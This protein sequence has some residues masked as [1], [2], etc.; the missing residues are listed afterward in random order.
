MYFIYFLLSILDQ[1]TFIALK[2]K[3][4]EKF[5][6]NLCRMDMRDIFKNSFY[7]QRDLE[8]ILTNT[9]SVTRL[10]NLYINRNFLLVQ[11]SSKNEFI[12]SVRHDYLLQFQPHYLLD[13]NFNSFLICFESFLIFLYSDQTKNWHSFKEFW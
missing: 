8:A 3:L 9:W 13:E 4:H 5:L 11:K 2:K 7:Y 12:C 6:L 10:W 1:K